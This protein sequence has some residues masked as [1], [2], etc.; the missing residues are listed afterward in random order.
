MTLEVQKFLREH[1]LA[2]LSSRFYIKTRRHILH[3]NLV[4]LKYH[5]VDSPFGERIVQECR[6]IILD[7][8]SNWAVV[9]RTFDKFFNHGEGHAATIDWSTARVQEKLDGSLMQV[10]WYKGQWYV[11]SSGT[12]DASG[13]VVC[14]QRAG[15]ATFENLFWATWEELGYKTEWL[16]SNYTYAFELMTPFNRVVVPH[17]NG[18][19]ALIGMRDLLFGEEKRPSEFEHCLKFER[20]QEFPLQSFEDC[21]TS[22]QHIDPMSQEGYVVVDGGFHRVKMKHPGYV[23]LSHL[24]DGLGQRRVL[25][26]I[27]T[28]ETS[29]VLTYFPAWKPVFDSIGARFGALVQSVERDWAKLQSMPMGASGDQKAFAMEAKKNAYPAALFELRKGSVKSV[30]EYFAKVHI[31]HLLRHLDIADEDPEVE[32]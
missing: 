16:Q 20:P 14:T 9:A 12:P 11:A 26:I 31:K 28:G 7:E 24:K 21:V 19:L 2:E 25:E 3:P 6:G 1:S 30:R 32:E 8:D 22:F 27:R 15:E 5:Q 29:E 23:A 17:K 13:N 10:Y 18:R 4:C